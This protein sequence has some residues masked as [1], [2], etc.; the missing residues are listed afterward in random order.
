M[1]YKGT[2]WLLVNN[3]GALDEIANAYEQWM[4]PKPKKPKP[5]PTQ[6]PVDEDEAKKVQD[7]IV[8]STGGK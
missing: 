5:E 7:A 3:M 8:K 1:P 2:Y 4:K 6:T